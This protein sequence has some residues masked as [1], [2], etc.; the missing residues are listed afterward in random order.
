MGP[1]L[2]ESLWPGFRQRRPEPKSRSDA[3]FRRY[4]L[5]VRRFLS[6]TAFV[7]AVAFLPAFAQIHG[8]PPS[9]T[10]LGPRGFG[11]G[12]FGGFHG[13]F[14]GGFHSGFGGGFRGG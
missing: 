2:N 9:V 5:P 11:G 13:G 1:I 10:S 3:S 8:V 4:N 7:L 12:G 14:G 6:I